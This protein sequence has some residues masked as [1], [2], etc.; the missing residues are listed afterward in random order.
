MKRERRNETQHTPKNTHTG[1]CTH[2]ANNTSGVQV[3]AGNDNAVV[4]GAFLS[5]GKHCIWKCWNQSNEYVVCVMRRAI[6]QIR[7]HK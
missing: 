7:H 3:I 6:E 2:S 5:R 1:L 4:D